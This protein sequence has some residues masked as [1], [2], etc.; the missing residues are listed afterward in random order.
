M[1]CGLSYG[2][3]IMKDGEVMETL[4]RDFFEDW[5][6]DEE[7]S[8]SFFYR[9]ESHD[10]AH[11]IFRG[12]FKAGDEPLHKQISRNPKDKNE[13]VWFV[14]IEKHKNSVVLI[15]YFH[16]VS[17]EMKF[18]LVR[19]YIVWKEGGAIALVPS[20]IFPNPEGTIDDFAI[21]MI[22]NIGEW[23]TFTKGQIR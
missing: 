5:D 10:D 21:Y 1:I 9:A 18:D 13:M 23:L 4:P 20:Q 8:T 14:P 19:M 15:V 7:E 22:N 6:L 2:Q 16:K 3:S 11:R 17:G 12:E